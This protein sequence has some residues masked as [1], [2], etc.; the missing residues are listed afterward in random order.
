MDIKGKLFKTLA[1]K[2][3]VIFLIIYTISYIIGE[4]IYTLKFGG[5]TVYISI[6]FI[7]V[8]FI[9]SVIM[10][11][12]LL[13]LEAKF[14]L[15]ILF[16]LPVIVFGVFRLVEIF[17]S[18]SVSPSDY[19]LSIIL[20]TVS[21]ILAIS[22]LFSKFFVSEEKIFAASEKK[23]EKIVKSVL[24]SQDRYREAL[25]RKKEDWEKVIEEE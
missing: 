16:T 8:V 25:E 3:S 7:A 22:F 4:L 18:E 15:Y 10:F 20:L 6:I 11:F 21:V 2:L 24:E 19:I 23:R 1:G 17:T 14:F 12:L 13:K 9:S 5:N